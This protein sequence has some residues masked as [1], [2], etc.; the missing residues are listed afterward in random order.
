[1][2]TSLLFSSYPFISGEKVTLTRVTDMDAEALWL[3]L[4][5]EDTHRFTPEG[6]VH[7]S[8]ECAARLRQFDTLFQERRGVVLGIYS[9]LNQLV[10]LLEISHLDR[11]VESV[12]LSFM[13]LPE[14]T[15]QGYASA[16]VR[17]A[18][19]YLLRT[20]GVHR[21]QCFVLPINYRAVLVLERC[22]FVKEGTIREGF[23]WPYQL[24][25]GAG[26]GAVRLCEGGHHSGGLPLAGQGHRG[27]DPLLP[28]AHGPE[29]Q[30]GQPFPIFLTSDTKRPLR[31]K[32][33]AFSIGQRRPA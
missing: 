12:T 4:S 15:G 28:A 3:L 10:G 5:D 7:S 6:A 19:D 22:G 33:G 2:K 17:A 27:S 9:T 13:L 24:P 11:Q 30:A 31:A 21:I 14:Y 26:A 18:C 29:T 20:V 16:A 1:M 8:R 32:E 23:L 25:G